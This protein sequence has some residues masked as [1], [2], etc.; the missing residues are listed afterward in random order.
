MEYHY[1]EDIWGAQI[2]LREITR[3]IMR[4]FIIWSYGHAWMKTPKSRRIQKQTHYGPS[5]TTQQIR[6]KKKKKKKR[7]SK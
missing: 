3:E 1:S 6:K 2:N 7:E 4:G 5:R